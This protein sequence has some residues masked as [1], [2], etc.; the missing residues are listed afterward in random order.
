M[1]HVLR[2]LVGN[3]RAAAAVDYSLIAAIIAVAGISAMRA[4]GAKSAT[5]LNTAVTALT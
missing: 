5:A 1:L 4:I 3:T 2:S